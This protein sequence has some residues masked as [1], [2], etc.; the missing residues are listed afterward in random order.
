MTP[1]PGHRPGW[2]HIETNSG[3]PEVIPIV[4]GISAG[5]WTTC[6]R[7]QVEVVRLGLKRRQQVVCPLYKEDSLRKKMESVALWKLARRVNQAK[8]CMGPL[9]IKRQTIFPVEPFQP[10]PAAKWLRQGEIT[11]TGTYSFSFTEKE[12]ICEKATHDVKRAWAWLMVDNAK[13]EG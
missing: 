8:N 9:M 3:Q 7:T 4:G 11:E 10:R 13:E 12:G 2:S 6:G 1:H 5:G